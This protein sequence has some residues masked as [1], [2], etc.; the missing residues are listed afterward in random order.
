MSIN[1]K[2]Y[3]IDDLISKY[4][5]NNNTTKIKLSIMHINIQSLSAKFDNLKNLVGIL[6]D[7]GVELNFIL[8]VL[9]ET[10]HDGHSNLFE[11]P[12]Y[13]LVHKNRK[14]RSRGGVA[15][16]VKSDREYKIRDD[17]YPF[18]MKVNLNRFL[19]KQIHVLQS[20]L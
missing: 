3:D 5:Q 15:I 9:C 7:N 2:Y 12:G 20:I 11:L 1:S 8:H 4:K 16:Y 18:L 14:N 6:Q 19:S 13:N 10:L 17:I